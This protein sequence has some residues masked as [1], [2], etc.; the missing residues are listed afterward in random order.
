M[1]CIR[2][3]RFTPQ[4]SHLKFQ[5]VNR[6]RSGNFQPFSA[7]LNYHFI[8]STFHLIRPGK[9]ELFTIFSRTRLRQNQNYDEYKKQILKKPSDSVAQLSTEKKNLGEEGQCCVLYFENCYYDNNNVMWCVRQPR[10]MSMRARKRL[11]NRY[12]TVARA[13]ARDLCIRTL[14]C[15]NKRI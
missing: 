14:A 2:Q 11:I 3:K 12:K 8:F 1:R 13:I 6:T 10:K 9:F 4:K 5:L 7:S 15:D